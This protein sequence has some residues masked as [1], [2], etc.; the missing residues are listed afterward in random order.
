MNEVTRDFIE[1]LAIIAV[2]MIG[3]GFWFSPDVESQT[4][5]VLCKSTSTGA[6][7]VFNGHS[8]PHGWILVGPA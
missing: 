5:R 8:C 7:Q 4:A 3:L 6:V 1:W 2:I